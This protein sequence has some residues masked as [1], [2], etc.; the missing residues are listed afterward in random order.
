MNCLSRL[1]EGKLIEKLL[2][3][4]VALVCESAVTHQCDLQFTVALATDTVNSRMTNN[5]TE[6]K[7]IVCG[8]RARLFIGLIKVS[9]KA[10]RPY[11]FF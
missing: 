10:A 2:T 4:N 5:S 8:S 3:T 7:V 11:H 1:I 6:S 9:V